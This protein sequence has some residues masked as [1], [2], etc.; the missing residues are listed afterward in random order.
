M[1]TKVL[2]IVSLVMVLFTVNAMAAEAGRWAVGARLGYS[3][4]EDDTIGNGDS[5]VDD[6]FMA[7]LNLTYKYQN[8]SLELGVDYVPDTDHTVTSPAGTSLKMGEIKQIPITLTARYHFPINNFS[9]YIGAGVGYYLND[10]T[11]DSLIEMAGFKADVDDSFGYFVNA[12][13]E[14]FIDTAKQWAMNL[15]LKYIWNEADYKIT[16]GAVTQTEDLGLDSF[17]MGVGV[18]YYF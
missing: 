12:G 3:F 18:K 7:G 10:Y 1:K 14:I 5:S 4:F 15:D 16:D 11:T 2:L 6:S 8:M 17:V 13:T 9:P